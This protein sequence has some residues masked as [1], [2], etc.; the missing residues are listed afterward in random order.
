MTN[1][2][3]RDHNISLQQLLEQRVKLSED[4][5]AVVFNNKA[6]SFSQLE[7]RANKLANLLVENQI[8]PQDRVAIL[9]DRS[10]D[11]IV[12]ILAI[13]KVGATYIPID[14]NY[15]HS[16]IEYMLEDSQ[17][18]AA[19]LDESG[20]EFVGLMSLQLGISFIPVAECESMPSDFE[21]YT[22]QPFD[23]AYIIYTSGSTGKP[24]G[25]CV[26]YQNLLNFNAGMQECIGVVNVSAI[27][28]L[29]TICFDI[30]VLESIVALLQG[31][32]VYLVSDD[33]RKS[34]IPLTQVIESVDALQIT[35]SHLGLLLESSV[36]T[37]ALSKLRLLLIGGEAL[38]Q[39]LLE[40]LKGVTSAR[41]FNMYG[42]TETTVWSC[43]QELTHRSQVDIGFPILNTQVYVLDEKER[44]VE[45]GEVGELCIAGAGV[46]AGYWNKPELTAK[47]FIRHPLVPNG[48]LYKTGDLGLRNPDGSYRCLGRKDHQVKVNGHRI[49]LGDI[50][51]HI[52][53]VSGVQH[54]GVVLSQGLC[55]LIRLEDMAA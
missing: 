27:A 41:L 35:P 10:V 21:M 43:V 9:L 22:S 19:L 28:S 3:D 33:Q 26:T 4:K 31:V 11:T 18:Q 46:S 1:G 49:E 30:F 25:V 12:S 38:P 20:A 53:S 17:C 37:E 36:S 23:L 47:C 29:T 5:K 54:V 42:P 40:K 55:C 51:S 32:C 24:K 50:E 44:P 13:L 8:K 16:R 14:L 15:P 6:I 2:F 48:Q 45:D 34:A 52:L 39:P 7:D